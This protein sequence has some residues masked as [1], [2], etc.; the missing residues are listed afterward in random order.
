MKQ[1]DIST[2]GFHDTCFTTKIF[3]LDFKNEKLLNHVVLFS[4]QSLLRK[5]TLGY[6][7]P[8]GGQTHIKSEWRPFLH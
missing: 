3:M 1:D 2:S 6:K 8:G 4:F 7:Y 5:F